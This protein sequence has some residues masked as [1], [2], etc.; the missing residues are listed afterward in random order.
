MVKCHQNTIVLSFMDCFRRFERLIT[1]RQMVLLRLAPKLRR[2]QRVAR[3][4]SSPAE[5]AE[6]ST[7]RNLCL[8]CLQ[9][10]AK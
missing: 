9:D 1:H 3:V 10:Y 5:A 8:Q 2:H 4:R 6:Q 7:W